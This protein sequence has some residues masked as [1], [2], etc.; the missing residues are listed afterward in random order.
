VLDK[1]AL[2]QA[3]SQYFGSPANH[4]STN[5]SIVKITR[6][7]PL[8]RVDPTGLH[9]TMPIKKKGPKLVFFLV[10]LQIYNLLQ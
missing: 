5:F 4:H 7:W 2:G 8:C 9:P 10:L 3:F 1:V 6:G